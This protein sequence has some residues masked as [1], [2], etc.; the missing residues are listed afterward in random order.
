MAFDVG[1]TIILRAS[2]TNDAGTATD[3][4]TPVTVKVRDKDGNVTDATA[5]KIS[6]G[7]YE[8]EFSIVTSGR[9][10]YTFYTADD[11]IEQGTFIAQVDIAGS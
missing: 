9:H 7:V 11:A 10:Y 1:E 6:T 3:P 4:S 5:T 8:Y 2:A